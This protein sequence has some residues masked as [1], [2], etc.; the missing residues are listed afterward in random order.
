MLNSRQRNR[1]RLPIAGLWRGQAD[2]EGQKSGVASPHSLA[3]AEKEERS[4]P[5]AFASEH[6]TSNEESRSV[7]YPSRP[8][9][10]CVSKLTDA[11]GEQAETQHP[12]E[13][14]HSV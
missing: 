1:L 7:T 3:V 2:D 5:K 11:D 9:A 10:K 13:H 14:S 4:T 12:V 8:C 6:P